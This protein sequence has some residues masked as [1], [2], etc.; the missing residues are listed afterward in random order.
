M[1]NIRLIFINIDN[2]E[3]DRTFTIEQLVEDFWNE[4]M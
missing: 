2:V 3:I 4:C 1:K